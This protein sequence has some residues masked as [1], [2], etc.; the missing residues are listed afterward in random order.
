MLDITACSL[1]KPFDD[2]HCPTDICSRCPGLQSSALSGPD[3]PFQ[4]P[5]PALHLRV[6]TS[7]SLQQCLLLH[8]PLSKLLSRT[9]VMIYYPS[10]EQ[11]KGLGFLSQ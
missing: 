1:L 8:L 3:L 11:S 9:V 4:L 5:R 6:Q 2:P 7:S 10:V